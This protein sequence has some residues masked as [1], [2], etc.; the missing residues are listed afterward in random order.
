LRR[1][2]RKGTGPPSSGAG[3]AFEDGCD[4]GGCEIF[5]SG[6]RGFSLLSR[7]FFSGLESAMRTLPVFL[8]SLV[9]L[10]CSVVLAGPEP[11]R[12]PKRSASD[13]LTVPV[14]WAFVAPAQIFPE[15]ASV[16]GL[17]LNLILGVNENVT[18]IDIGLVNTTVNRF[19]GIGLGIVNDVGTEASALH[20]GA[21][22]LCF[23]SYAG[24]QLAALLNSVE[25]D[26]SA[27]QLGPINSVKGDMSGFQIGFINIAGTLKG[28]QIGLININSGSDTLGFMPFFNMAF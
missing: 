12:A 15:T 3:E 21:V 11:E 14:Q 28:V 22:N 16:E 17:R 19:S 18:G 24:I 2:E 8:G 27:F 9:S 20:I 7:E 23:G 6:G 1:G 4:A 25:G 26:S 5:G 10:F 13:K